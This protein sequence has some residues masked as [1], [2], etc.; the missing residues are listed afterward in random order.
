MEL[1]GAS[2]TIRKRV[3]SRLGSSLL[4][5][6]RLFINDFGTSKIAYGIVGNTTDALEV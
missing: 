4:N 1:D 3:V 5:A 2:P 6:E